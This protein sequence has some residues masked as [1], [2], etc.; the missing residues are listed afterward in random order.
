MLLRQAIIGDFPRI[1]ARLRLGRRYRV[2][3]SQIMI[4]Y[5]ALHD[6]SMTGI[7]KTKLEALQDK[8]TTL[9][10]LFRELKNSPLAQENPE[11]YNI[12]EDI[13]R[14][15]H[16]L[17]QSAEVATALNT[18]LR[19][20]FKERT[21]LQD[22]L[23]KLGQYYKASSDLVLAARRRKTRIFRRIRVKS[24]QI[25]VPNSVRFP[26]EPKSALPLI[27]DLAISPET[28]RLLGRF[29]GSESAASAAVLRRLDSSRSGIKIHAEIKLLFYY[30]LHPDSVRPR[31]LC[32]NKSACYLCDLFIRIHG[33]FQTPRTFGKFNERWIL[34]DWLDSIP[35][36]RAQALGNMVEQ[37]STI[38]DSEIGLALRSIK[39]LPD[40]LES[41][42]GLPAQWSSLTIA[43]GPCS[44]PV[45]GRDTFVSVFPPPELNSGPFE[46]LE[47]LQLPKV[48]QLRSKMLEY[49]EE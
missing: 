1:F 4:L 12:T 42:V 34:P 17:N 48:R 26:S 39:R 38:L 29:H 21:S 11:A 8:A 49:D 20:S 40:P 18:T 9:L 14:L 47:T 10:D 46:N 45:L 31:V 19:L 13:I 5:Q 44:S 28:S 6:M 3:A 37:F 25:S 16:D 33:E 30:E 35:P 36:S 32:A 24:F 23:V 2:E 41:A 22:T 15:V 43:D 7:E 27:Q